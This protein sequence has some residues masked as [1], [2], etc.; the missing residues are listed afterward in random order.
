MAMP[1]S[2]EIKRVTH[3]WPLLSSVLTQGPEAR[4]SSQFTDRREVISSKGGV[5]E[6]WLP[7]PWGSVL[8]SQLLPCKSTKEVGRARGGSVSF[9]SPLFLPSPGE[10]LQAMLR[11]RPDWTLQVEAMVGFWCLNKMF[12][13]IKSTKRGRDK[14]RNPKTIDPRGPWWSDRCPKEPSS[15]KINV[16]H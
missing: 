4:C 3:H 16:I 11:R 12:K 15:M 5:T 8:C 13:G 14:V 2:Q 1:G 9:L 6:V 7:P 10:S